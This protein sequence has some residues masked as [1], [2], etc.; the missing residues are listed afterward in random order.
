MPGRFNT[1][2]V[3][4]ETLAE[5]QRQRFEDEMLM[6]LKKEY[7]AVLGRRDDSWVRELIREGIRQAKEYDIVLERDVARYLE[8]MLSLSPDFDESSKTPWAREILTDS[9]LEAGEKL[10]EI[11]EHIIFGEDEQRLRGN[12]AD[13]VPQPFNR[14]GVLRADKGFRAEHQDVGRGRLTM[15]WEDEEDRQAW[16]AEYQTALDDLK[17]PSPTSRPGL[18]VGTPV[19]RRPEP[20][21]GNLTVTLVDAE[22]GEA[23]AGASVQ[24]SGPVT[25]G[26]VSDDSGDACFVGIETGDYEIVAMDFQHRSAQGEATVKRGM[27]RVSLTCR[28]VSGRTTVR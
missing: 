28:Q 13:R 12:S 23:I 17:A 7:A 24:A 6:Y 1:T 14:A 4:F 26:T 18:E 16:M 21:T 2:N 8:L 3:H 19:A 9:E 11:Y 20:I 25:E 5:Q 10:D 15:Q 27:T 22:S